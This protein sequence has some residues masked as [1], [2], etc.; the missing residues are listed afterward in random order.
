M[1]QERA[2][3]R[4]VAWERGEGDEGQDALQLSNAVHTHTTHTHTQTHTHTH[5]HFHHTSSSKEEKRTETR[6]DCTKE[7]IQPR[8][9]HTHAHHTHAHTHTHTHAHTHSDSSRRTAQPP[10][11]SATVTTKAEEST[12]SKRRWGTR[13]N[14]LLPPKK[15]RLFSLPLCSPRCARAPERHR[16]QR[17]NAGGSSGNRAEEKR[18]ERKRERRRRRRKKGRTN[19]LSV[20]VMFSFSLS[21]SLSSSAVL[22]ASA[23]HRGPLLPPLLGRP[24]RQR[25]PRSVLCGRPYRARRGGRRWRPGGRGGGRRRGAWRRGGRQKEKASERVCVCEA[26]VSAAAEWR[27]EDGRSGGRSGRRTHGGCRPQGVL[28]MWLAGHARR[29]VPLSLPPWPL[30]FSCVERARTRGTM[31][32]QRPRLNTVFVDALVRRGRISPA[33][34][35]SGKRKG[36]ATKRVSGGFSSPPVLHLLRTRH[37]GRCIDGGLWIVHCGL[38]L[39]GP[40]TKAGAGGQRERGKGATSV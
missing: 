27:R 6:G 17:R 18:E 28:H 34:R 2:G 23:V 8:S 11:G 3:G 20:S 9:F 40:E 32:S 33:L 14:P 16:I 25:T 5:T 21:F 19:F 37:H 35:R 38:P 39:P 30:L 15:R 1:S 7:K 13:C 24:G 36:E 10:Q 29:A 31:A 22:S 4:A 26:E 12:S